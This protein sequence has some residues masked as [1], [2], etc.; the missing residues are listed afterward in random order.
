MLTLISSEC[1]H[2][3]CRAR[4]DGRS[5]PLD[6]VSEPEI[7]SAISSTAISLLNSM[8]DGEISAEVKDNKNINEMRKRMSMNARSELGSRPIFSFK[9]MSLIMASGSSISTIEDTLYSSFRRCIKDCEKQPPIPMQHRST[10]SLRPN[11]L[12]D[13]YIRQVVQTEGSEQYA[14]LSYTW[15]NMTTIDPQYILF[16]QGK[17]PRTVE[18]AIL[19]VRRLHLRYLWIDRYCINQGDV[20]QRSQ[21][22]ENMLNIFQGAS[23]ILAAPGPHEH[24]GL[25]SLS[26]KWR[27]SHHQLLSRKGTAASMSLEPGCRARNSMFQDRGV[28]RRVLFFDEKSSYLWS[29][30]D[31]QPKENFD[32]QPNAYTDG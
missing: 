32:N 12:L 3:Y 21:D 5:Q 24:Y 17:A 8:S 10:D 27:I 11:Y 23:I 7:S 25:P 14:C 26:T 9:H 4:G 18:D 20:M 1:K 2:K 31:A 6:L 19:V 30:S 28:S 16:R 15:G 29:K 13:C 22:V